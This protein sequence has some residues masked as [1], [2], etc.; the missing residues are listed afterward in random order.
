MRANLAD[1][2]MGHRAYFGSGGL[3]SYFT[4]DSYWK[5]TE[6]SWE[7]DGHERVWTSSLCQLS[8]WPYGLQ[9]I[10]E[11]HDRRARSLQ[12]ER[13]SASHP[14]RR[15]AAHLRLAKTPILRGGGRLAV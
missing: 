11:A 13:A 8:S 14:L 3:V 15:S 10:G 5:I 7:N 6:S 9:T 2:V 12:L 1:E 4:G